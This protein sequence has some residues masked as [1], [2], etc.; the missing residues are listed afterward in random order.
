MARRKSLFD[1][2]D[3]PQAAHLRPVDKLVLVYLKWRQGDKAR[4][5]PSLRSIADDLHIDK[6]NCLRSIERLCDGGCL[7]KASGRCG[8][9]HSNRYVILPEKRGLDDT[10]SDAE[11]GGV[12]T[13]FNREKR[14]QTCAQKGANSP[15]KEQEKEPITTTA[16]NLSLSLGKSDPK[17]NRCKPTRFTP[18][19]VEDVQQYA[20]S[21]G[22]PDFDAEYFVEHYAT[23]DWHDVKG[24]QVCNWKQK[25]LTW[26]KRDRDR[27]K[28]KPDDDGYSRFGTHPA[29][30][31]EIQ[32]LEE[33]GVL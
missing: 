19:T 22:A 25:I 30:E 10:F 5:W 2:L 11:K 15:L 27:A 17:A 6:R 4:C 8:R 29:T 32:A 21:R 20:A 33:A 1:V 31:A 23:A 3:F 9:G 18:P 28:V 14:G 26:L 24:N 12:L 7:Q 13:P 16:Q